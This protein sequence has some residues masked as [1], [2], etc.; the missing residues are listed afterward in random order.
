MFD[1]FDEDHGGTVDPEEINKVLEEIGLKKRNET[2]AAII[3]AL[4]NKNKSIR[5]DEFVEIVGHKVG[6]LKSK[7]GLSKVFDMFDKDSTGLITF[8]NFKQLARELG[9][10]MNDD[11]IVEMMHNAYIL[12]NTPSHEGFNFD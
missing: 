1:L 2:V 7:E 6:D 11:E 9:E 10:M 5:F 4:K 8:D 12:N 3:E